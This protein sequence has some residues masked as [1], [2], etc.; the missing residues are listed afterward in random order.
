MSLSTRY[1]VPDTKYLIGVDEA[2]RGPLAGPL[3]LSALLVRDQ[4]VLRQFAGIKDSKKLS[5][6]K[7]EKWF[8]KIKE[9]EKRGALVTETVLVE[10]TAIDR[11]GMGRCLRD[12]TATALARFT[13]EKDK[14]LVLLDGALYAPRM[15]PHQ[16]TIIKGDEKERVIA[17]A[18][19]VA[20]VTRDR[21]MYLL[22]KKYPLYGFERHKG[23]GTAAHYLAIKAHGVSA[24]HRR[25][26]LRKMSNA[27][28]TPMTKSQ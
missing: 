7:R 20:K 17:M 23:Y 28:K 11:K 12:A 16:A 5:E 21:A 3:A 9:A 18:S 4:R 2:G 10:N 13:P 14:V 6:A 15:F 24:V 26:F 22:A 1:H 27:N 25:S 19:V 8:L